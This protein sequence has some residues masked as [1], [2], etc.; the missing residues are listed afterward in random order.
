MTDIPAHLRGP[1]PFNPE[2]QAQMIADHC[3]NRLEQELRVA[4]LT[5]APTITNVSDVMDVIMPV[6]RRH[7]R[8]TV[9]AS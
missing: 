6:V 3:S 2:K 5:L 4:L 1:A 8:S 9:G 7:V